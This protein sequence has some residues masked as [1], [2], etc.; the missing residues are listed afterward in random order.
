MIST[1]RRSAA[2]AASSTRTYCSGMSVGTSFHRRED[3]SKAGKSI[4]GHVRSRKQ[5]REKMGSENAGGSRSPG[6]SRTCASV[7]G[8]GRLRRV[9][10]PLA[11]LL[12]EQVGNRNGDRHEGKAQQNHQSDQET[13]EHGYSL[14]RKA[15][16]WCRGEVRNDSAPA[17]M[18]LIEPAVSST[19]SLTPASESMPCSRMAMN[20]SSGSMPSRCKFAMRSV[21]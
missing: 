15:F 2:R 8:S 5:T 12:E 20:T 14:F 19:A 17:G 4:T 11:P 6:R 10:Q 21:P 7:A 3:I 18:M 13:L 16:M 9:A 1:P